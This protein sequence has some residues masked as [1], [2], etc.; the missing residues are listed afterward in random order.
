MIIVLT[1]CCNETINGA[2][3]ESTDQ[4]FARLEEHVMKFRRNDER[5]GCELFLPRLPFLPFSV[6]LPAPVAFSVNLPW[7][8]RNMKLVTYESENVPCAGVVV[9]EQVLEVATM[10]GEQGG[11][12][13]VCA[14]LELPN[15]PLTRLKSALGSARAGQGVPLERAPAGADLAAANGTRLHGVRGTCQRRRHAA[16]LRRLVSAAD[17]LLL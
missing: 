13:D 11:L 5:C 2:D 10:L 12:R 7:F 6:L 1:F 9:D 17:F 4:I 3:S 16:T 8:T 14:L 15:D